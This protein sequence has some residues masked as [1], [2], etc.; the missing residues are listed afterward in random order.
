MSDSIKWSI[1]GKEVDLNNMTLTGTRREGPEREEIEWTL[2]DL[3]QP[4][5]G[6]DYGPLMDVLYKAFEQASGGKGKERHANG[7][8]FLDQPIMHI[9]GMVGL[10]FPT[11]QVQKK[12]QEAVKM[13]EAGR[14]EAAQRELLGAIVYAAAA[15]LAVEGRG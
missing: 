4:E 11:G 13:V 14:P 3:I 15:Y 2:E 8:D 6:P 9:T 5:E 1:G 10:G 12:T 7:R